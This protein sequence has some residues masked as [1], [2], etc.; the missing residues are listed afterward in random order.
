MCMSAI[1]G[2]VG[3]GA[4]Y[5]V[6]GSAVGKYLLRYAWCKDLNPVVTSYGTDGEEN[7]FVA[8]V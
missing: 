7:M 8:S 4:C 1:C 3:Y 5:N 2:M 6:R